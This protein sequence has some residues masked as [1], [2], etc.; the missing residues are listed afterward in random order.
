MI[1]VPDYFKPIPMNGA[2]HNVCVWVAQAQKAR[3]SLMCQAIQ[4]LIFPEHVE[5]TKLTIINQRPFD[6]NMKDHESK[7]VGVLQ[8]IN[9]L[10]Q[11]G[12]PIPFD[13]NRQHLVEASL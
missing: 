10:D 2:I 3:I 11:Y 1:P 6:G 4:T 8:L 7:T 9:A 13:S 5:Q 12:T